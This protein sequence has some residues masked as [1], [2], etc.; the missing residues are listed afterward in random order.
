MD[1]ELLLGQIVCSVALAS[2]PPTYK[3]MTFFPLSS[4]AFLRFP[5][6]LKKVGR[7]QL[8]VD[9]IAADALSFDHRGNRRNAEELRGAVSSLKR[10]D[11][12][13]YRL[14]GSKS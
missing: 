2:H 9:G 11:R 6:C 13:G 7:W 1:S 3:P 10:G 4:S 12:N 5:L 8:V 14:W